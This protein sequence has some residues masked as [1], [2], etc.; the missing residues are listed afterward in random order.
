LHFNIECPTIRK[1]ENAPRKGVFDFPV[2]GGLLFTVIRQLLR[3][4]LW[5]Y[6]SASW[7]NLTQIPQITQ[8]HP[9][10]NLLLRRFWAAYAARFRRCHPDTNH[11]WC[12]C[13][14][15][16]SIFEAVLPVRA[17]DPHEPATVRPFEGPS[18]R[19]IV[20]LPIPKGLR[21]TFLSTHA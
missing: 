8:I 15:I 13:K 5:P 2:H 18:L 14:L 9:V 19:L 1:S 17:P 11:V 4:W 7:G 16:T 3:C 21:P 6:L 20:G 12:F 10:S